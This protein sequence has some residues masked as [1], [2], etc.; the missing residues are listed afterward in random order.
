MKTYTMTVASIPFLK[1]ASGEKKIESR[2]F[3]EKRQLLKIGDRIIFIKDNNPDQKVLVEIKN[4]FFYPTFLELF[5]NHSPTLFGGESIDFL[6]QEIRQFYS[7]TKEK[8]F[9]V[10][11]IYFDLV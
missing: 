2:L 4:L 5:S 10:L 9:G 11:G 7:K 8:E 6:Y 3:D 1:I